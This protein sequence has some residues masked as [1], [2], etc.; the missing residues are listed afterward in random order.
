VCLFVCLFVCLCVSMCVRVYGCECAHVYVYAR[1]RA[2]NKCNIPIKLQCVAACCSVLQR[3]AA[4]CSVLQRVAACCSVSQYCDSV[5]KAILRRTV[6]KM[7][8]KSK[9]AGLFPQKVTNHRALLWK[10]SCKDKASDASLPPC[11]VL[12]AVLQSKQ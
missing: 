7:H 4:C 11:S 3:V 5:T 9:V 2:C 12:N 1:V 10:K 8:R 6:A